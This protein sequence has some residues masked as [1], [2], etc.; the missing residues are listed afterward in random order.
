MFYRIQ[1]NKKKF[2]E[3][4]IDD[5]QEERAKNFN[6]ETNNDDLPFAK[7]A[8]AS[9]WHRWALRRKGGCSSCSPD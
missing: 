5:S 7:A 2:N 8:L 3:E 9:P 6:E 4:A 1:N